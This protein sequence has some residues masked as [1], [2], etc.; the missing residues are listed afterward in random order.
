MLLHYAII[1]KETREQRLR[2]NL[3][4]NWL[5]SQV[6]TPALSLLKSGLTLWPFVTILMPK[7]SVTTVWHKPNKMPISPAASLMIMRWFFKIIFY[8]SMCSSCWKSKAR[9]IIGGFSWPFRKV[10]PIVNIFF[11]KADSVW[12]CKVFL[13]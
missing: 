5:H 2:V 8:T 12:Q 11:V 6:S 9:P 13:V 7:T 10:V 4:D 1:I 3:S